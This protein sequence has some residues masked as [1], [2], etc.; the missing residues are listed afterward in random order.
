MTATTLG[1]M[2]IAFVFGWSLRGIVMTR[3]LLSELKKAKV[4]NAD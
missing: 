4:S 1:W 3:W 2:A